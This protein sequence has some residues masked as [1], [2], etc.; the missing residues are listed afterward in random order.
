MAKCSKMFAIS[1]LELWLSANSGWR[2]ISC[3]LSQP[4]LIIA[5]FT[6]MN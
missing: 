5:N 6:T 1:D 3:G 4:E 2:Y